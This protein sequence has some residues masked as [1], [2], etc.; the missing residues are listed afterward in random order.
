[1][2]TSCSSYCSLGKRRMEGK[3]DEKI[4]L[5]VQIYCNR[6]GNKMDVLLMMYPIGVIFMLAF[7]FMRV[8]DSKIELM[9]GN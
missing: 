6:G 2:S 9:Q 8:R 5:S 7:I 4:W 3:P 1:M